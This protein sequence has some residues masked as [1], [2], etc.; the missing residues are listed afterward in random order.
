M[1][2]ENSDCRLRRAGQIQS[3]FTG[4][5]K[6]GRG[7]LSAAVFLPLSFPDAR[8][9]AWADCR[10]TNFLRGNFSSN[11]ALIILRDLTADVPTIAVLLTR[12]FWTV[13]GF[14]RPEFTVVMHCLT[15]DV[16]SPI[17]RNKACRHMI[18]VSVSAVGERT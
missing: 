18:P 1:Q 2:S 4:T 3:V 15:D 11:V 10:S 14:V 9:S 7:F 16:N 13:D 8:S 5:A 17:V 12:C 6:H